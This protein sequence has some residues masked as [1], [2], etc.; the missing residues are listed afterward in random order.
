MCPNITSIYDSLLL[1]PMCSPSLCPLPPACTSTVPAVRILLVAGDDQSISI[2]QSPPI[3]SPD[4][5]ATAVPLPCL[6]KHRA[7]THSANSGKT[8]KKKRG[9]VPLCWVE[10]TERGR[11]RE[12]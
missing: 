5:A 1:T 3:E 12:S 4:T 8:E 7:R 10:D 9:K 11:E 6:T 2:H